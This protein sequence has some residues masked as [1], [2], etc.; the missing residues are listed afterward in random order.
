MVSVSPVTSCCST[1]QTLK[2]VSG[3]PRRTTAPGWAGR[4]PATRVAPVG[5]LGS[6][7]V[8]LGTRGVIA[9]HLCRNLQ[10]LRH[11]GRPKRQPEPPRES[12]PASACR[13]VEQSHAPVRGRGPRQA[14]ACRSQRRC[15]I[16][17]SPAG[18]PPASERRSR[19][20]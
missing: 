7:P 5:S 13:N 9:S 1:T 11:P 15:P 2:A 14:D 16:R 17:A 10:L 20:C 19:S 3:P 6:L 4:A 18:H 8:C 12:G